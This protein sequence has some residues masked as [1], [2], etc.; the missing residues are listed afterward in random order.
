M[1]SAV[2][3]LLCLTALAG[4]LGGDEPPAEA[5][6]ECAPDDIAC[7]CDGDAACI[8]A[9]TPPVDTDGDGLNDDTEAALGTDPDQADT[10]N[11]GVSD[12]DEVAAGTP[13][14]IP[15]YPNEGDSE[16]IDLELPSFDD[17]RIPV[18]IYKPAVAS[19][20]TPVPILLHS[21]GFTGS[22]I[23]GDDAVREYVAAGF[24]VVSFDERG[25]GDA[26]DDSDVKFMHPDWEV[27]DVIA[28][29]DHIATLDWVLMDP[30]PRPDGSPDPVVGTI[31]GSYGGA[32]QLMTHI[33]DDRIDAMVPEI[34][35]H[36]ITTALAPNGAIKSGWVDLFYL[37]GNAQQSVVFSND[38]HAGWA[39]A[40]ATNELP[41][42]QYGVAPDLVTG[43]NE[44][45]PESYPGALSVPTLLIQGMPDTLFPL[46]QAVWNYEEL[47]ANGAPVHLYTHLGGHVL[48][49]ESLAAGASPVPVGLQ[50]A[51]GGTPCGAVQ[52]LNI[53]WHQHWLLGL[54]K[55]LG[56]EVCIALEDGTAVVSDTFPL[57]GTEVQALDV[58]G[59][60][61]MA[62]AV[63]GTQ[64]PLYTFEAT[65]ETVVAGIPEL[66]GT[67]TSPGPDTI[68]YFSFQRL[69]ADGALE[70]IVDDQVRP[71]R[72]KGPNTGAVDFDM[73]LGGIAT[74]LA[75]GDQM[76]LMASSLEPM[77]FGNSE[78]LP[79]GVVLDGLTLELP[80]VASPVTKT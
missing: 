9:N 67:I 15:W 13:P 8:N 33:F 22:R 29:L 62:Q 47:Q 80:V 12:G 39:W 70:H 40:T 71:L 2:I 53:L 16:W 30:E 6:V 43:F 41:A 44:A 5:P 38:F 75:P 17:H 58:G 77:Y 48:N 1:R 42:D 26:R 64:V 79:S 36:N 46:N 73:E 25:H 18:S 65:E 63:G 3:L 21:H 74:R 27:R 54:P 28:V 60:W 20:A 31:G 51:P 55:D 57:N 68:V 56:P 45:S 32:F 35:W 14:T 78:R 10:D 7:Q 50:G 11:D 69:R 76:V 24:G 61:P 52:D 72:L 34:T 49:S 37:A 23:S 66:S 59:P 4:C 19:N